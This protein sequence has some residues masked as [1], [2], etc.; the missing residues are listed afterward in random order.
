MA[1]AEAEA[2]PR[3]YSAAVLY[4]ITFQAP[5]FY[6]RLGY[7]VL[8]RIEM[9]ATGYSRVCMTKRLSADGGP[10]ADV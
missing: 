2:K 8:G 5:G 7:Q 3:G 10:A 6:E 1:A 4:T 9:S